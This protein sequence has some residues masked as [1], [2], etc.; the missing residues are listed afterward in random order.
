LTRADNTRQLLDAAAARHDNATRRA[1]DALER[2]DRTGQ[3]ITFEAVART[4]GVSRGWLYR[5]PDLRADIIRL[6]ST[7]TSAP[8]VPSAQRASI[9]TLHQRLDTARDEIARLRVENT[10]LREQLARSLGRQRARR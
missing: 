3:P 5:Q 6:R 10:V 7:A 8:A 1:H 4:A 2:L 9:D